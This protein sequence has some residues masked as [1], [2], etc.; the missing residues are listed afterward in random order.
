MFLI[1][2]LFHPPSIISKKINKLLSFALK[3]AEVGGDSKKL[4]AKKQNHY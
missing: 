3:I 1:S 2:V 4:C